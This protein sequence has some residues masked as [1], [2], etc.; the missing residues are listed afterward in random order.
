[1]VANFLLREKSENKQRYKNKKNRRRGGGGYAPTDKASG[2]FLCA[3]M[4]LISLA[5]KRRQPPRQSQ[6]GSSLP[7]SGSSAGWLLAPRA[8]PLVL[9]ASQIDFYSGACLIAFG[10]P[11]F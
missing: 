4:R 1:M 10:K 2:V 8:T 6:L 9:F 5:A 11:R 7:R 3:V